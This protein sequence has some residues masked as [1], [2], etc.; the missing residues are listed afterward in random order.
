M[1]AS[2]QLLIDRMNSTK[3]KNEFVKLQTIHLYVV[4]KKPASEVAKI[5]NKKVGM[6]YQI[7]HRYKKMGIDGLINKP[8]GGRKWA[9]M[10]L[11]EEKK[12][13]ESLVSEANKGLVVI[14][15]IVRNNAE[16]KLGHP[17]SADYAEDLLNRH[18]WRKIMPKTKHPKSSSDEQEEFKKKCPNSSKKQRIRLTHKIIDL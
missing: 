5:V 16:E 2:I 10:S 15:K 11:A 9:F 12:L 8:R 4:E 13:L 3:D 18:G 17:V 14:S 7:A 1:D 6:I